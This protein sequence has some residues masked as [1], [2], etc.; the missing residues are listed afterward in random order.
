MENNEVTIIEVKTKEEDNRHDKNFGGIGE[1]IGRVFKFI[2]KVIRKGNSTFLEIRKTNEKPMRISLTV[3]ALLLVF[4]TI[5]SLILIGVGLFC[6]Y[7]YSISGR[8]TNY[9]GVNNVFDGISKS[10]NDIKDDFKKGYEK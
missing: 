2:G 8:S 9:D 10:A 3:L 4:L 1:T 6:G 7:K 5:P